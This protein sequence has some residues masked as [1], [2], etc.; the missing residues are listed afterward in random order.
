MDEDVTACLEKGRY[1]KD[2]SKNPSRD[3]SDILCKLLQQQAAPEVNNKYFDR[4]P[5]KYHSF[6][7]PIFQGRG[8]RME[9]L[10]RL[11]AFTVGETKE[12][13][14]HSVISLQRI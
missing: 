2:S 11:I 13:R 5:L 3:S 12:L 6:Y 10:A 4:F 7:D 8:K 14:K 9:T 1:L